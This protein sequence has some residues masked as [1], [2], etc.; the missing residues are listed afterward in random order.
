MYMNDCIRNY[1]LF[2]CIITVLLSFRLLA[3]WNFLHHQK[4]TEGFQFGGWPWGTMKMESPSS[5]K[6]HLHLHLR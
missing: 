6:N 1:V 2:N 5:L 4:S 3:L